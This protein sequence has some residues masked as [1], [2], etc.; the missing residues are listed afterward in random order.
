MN[1]K[2]LSTAIF[3]LFCFEA[4]AADV[5]VPGRSNPWLAGMP[6]G[7]RDGSDQAPY[8]SPV[9]VADVTLLAGGYLTITAT[10]YVN[11]APATCPSACNG[12]D[13][14]LTYFVTR[15]ALNSISGINAPA[16]ALI[17]VFLNDQPNS[18]AAPAPLDFSATGGVS[19]ATL[20]PLLNQV[21]FIGDGLTGTGSGSVQK[22]KVPAGASRLFLGTMDGS[23]WYNNVGSFSAVVN[24][25]GAPSEII[26][27]VSISDVNSDSTADLAGIIADPA[28]NYYYLVTYNGATGSRIKRISLGP[29]FT[30]APKKVITNAVTGNISVLIETVS[31]GAYQM[32]SFDRSSLA[33]VSTIN[34]Q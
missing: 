23:G 9:F 34:M 16:N 33:A 11:Y 20:S 5:A 3:A 6:D 8:Q 22:F 15:G 7:T 4:S 28:N 10:G 26:D 27:I 19:F 14:N 29:M 24:R 2:K 13:G 12:P 17:G 21:F 32:K 30:V 31:T 1:K 25:Q 18:G